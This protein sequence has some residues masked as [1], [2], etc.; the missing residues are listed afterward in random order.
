[1]PFNPRHPGTTTSQMSSTT[2]L[3]PIA[4]VGYDHQY[5]LQLR[6]ASQGVLQ[7]PV[8]SPAWI[9]PLLPHHLHM[10]APPQTEYVHPA[11]ALI[12]GVHPP[13]M[14]TASRMP[15]VPSA[16]AG[17]MAKSTL[18][19]HAREAKEVKRRTKTGCMTCRQRRIKVSVYLWVVPSKYVPTQI[20]CYGL[21]YL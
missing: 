10:Q 21:G 19:H 13:C 5:L 18:G 4:V 15:F 20:L 8:A 14:I 9:L 16:G 2:R 1:M 6:M 12:H 17:N 3:P 7:D 11:R